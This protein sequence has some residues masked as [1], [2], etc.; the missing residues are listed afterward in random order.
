MLLPKLMKRMRQ[1]IYEYPCIHPSFILFLGAA[2][3]GCVRHLLTVIAVGS[4]FG[5]I[6]YYKDNRFI[7]YKANGVK[8]ESRATIRCG[9][10]YPLF[11]Y[12]KMLI[13]DQQQSNQLFKRLA[14]FKPQQWFA[15]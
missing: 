8:K 3:A 7:D 11:S 2:G 10:R 13:S 12:P 6:L 9:K 14:Y 4:I 5:G 15:Q 1:L